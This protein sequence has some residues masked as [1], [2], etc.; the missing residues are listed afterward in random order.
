MASG[1]H[2]RSASD[3]ASRL[4]LENIY[5]NDERRRRRC[6]LTPLSAEKTKQKT[7]QLN[8]HMAVSLPR[9]GPARAD[10]PRRE[11]PKTPLKPPLIS[12]DCRLVTLRVQCVTLCVSEET[13]KLRKKQQ[14][15]KATIRSSHH[16]DTLIKSE[17]IKKIIPED[18]TL[19]RRS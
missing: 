18:F 2:R 11:S 14:G 13:L 12:K 8:Y 9:S 6:C 19:V 4:R 16:T 7:H 17:D 5:V 3:R 15:E 1:I 10:R